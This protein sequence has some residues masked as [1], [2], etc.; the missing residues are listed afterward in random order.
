MK[1]RKIHYVYMLLDP[2][3]PGLYIYTYNK[4]ELKI[5]YKPFYVGMGRGTQA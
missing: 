4:T 3:D 2:C 1:D 5:E